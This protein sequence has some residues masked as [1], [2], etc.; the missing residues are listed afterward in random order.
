MLPDGWSDMSGLR[1]AGACPVLP[2]I[3]GLGRPVTEIAAGLPAMERMPGE[4]AH[5]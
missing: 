1:P 3:G 4:A 2:S 5:A